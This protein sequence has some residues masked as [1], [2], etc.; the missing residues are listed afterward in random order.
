MVS[1]NSAEVNFI[2][3]TFFGGMLSLYRYNTGGVASDSRSADVFVYGQ[4]YACPL[5]PLCPF[6]P[7]PDAASRETAPDTRRA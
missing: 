6:R 5:C 7:L 1:L 4:I 3:Y 2:A